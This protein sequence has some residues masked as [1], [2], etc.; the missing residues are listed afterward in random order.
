MFYVYLCRCTP[1]VFSPSLL[2]FLWKC[3]R[4]AYSR[5]HTNAS[6]SHPH[7]K[8][9]TSTQQAHNIQQRDAPSPA[10]R[11]P[12][13]MS[14]LSTFTA[15]GIENATLYSA[16]INLTTALAAAQPSL[17]AKSKQLIASYQQLVSDTDLNST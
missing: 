1:F 11:N 12:L 7:N 8:H 17:T 5:V 15:D 2:A 3:P 4:G 16:A 14:L 9:T 6:R 13:S 10:H